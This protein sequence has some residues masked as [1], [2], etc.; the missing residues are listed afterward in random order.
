MRNNS[1]VARLERQ[2]NEARELVRGTNFDESPLAFKTLESLKVQLTVA[3]NPNH[4]AD[5][6]R[7][8]FAAR[9]A[10]REAA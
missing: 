3:K 10:R 8:W 9:A 1:A 2:V 7:Q 6:Y 4:Y 5:K